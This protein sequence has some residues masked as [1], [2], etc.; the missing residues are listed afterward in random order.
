MEAHS[1][2]QC[3]RIESLSEVG[4]GSAGIGGEGR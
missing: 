2:F 4:E 3:W 1:D